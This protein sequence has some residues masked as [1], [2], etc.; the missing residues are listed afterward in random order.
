M[1]QHAGDVF[2][3]DLLPQPVTSIKDPTRCRAIKPVLPSVGLLHGFRSG[4][5]GWRCSR[6]V[7]AITMEL[8]VWKCEFVVQLS[9]SERA[10]ASQNAMSQQFRSRQLRLCSL[11]VPKRRAAY[12]GDQ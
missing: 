9:G 1:Y 8:L 7:V 4:P 6:L 11:Q 5:G 2:R 12:R 10:G 3:Q